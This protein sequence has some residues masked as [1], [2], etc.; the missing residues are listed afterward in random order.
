MLTLPDL[1][2]VTLLPYRPVGSGFSWPAL[3]LAS[4]S[5]SPF[6]GPLLK[7]GRLPAS[8]VGGGD[9]GALLVAPLP[10]PQSAG[11]KETKAEVGKVEFHPLW[12]ACGGYIF[13]MGEGR[14][15]F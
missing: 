7:D 2:P 1:S 15:Y 6:P 8:W 10:T 4:K 3:P 12:E 14:R 11:D 13:R 9:P 5:R